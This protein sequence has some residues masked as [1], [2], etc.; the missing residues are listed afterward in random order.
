MRFFL[1]TLLPLAIAS[2]ELAF[3]FPNAVE[4]WYAQSLY[5]RVVSFFALV[6]HQS[7]SWAE[8]ALALMI[9]GAVSM[10]LRFARSKKRHRWKRGLVVLW[11][12]AGALAWAF[13]LLWGFNYARPPL[14]TRMGLATVDVDPSRVLKL[15]ERTARRTADLYESLALVDGPSELTISM[16]ELDATIDR[17]YR[18]L[19]LPGDVIVTRGAPV[20]TLAS[21]TMLSYLGISGIFIPFTGEPSVNA[22]QP[23]VALPLVVAHEKAHQ[24]GITHEGEANFVAFL[25]CASKS[26]PDYLRYAAHLFATR[27]LLEEAG[28]YW[29]S[30]EVRE[31]W[32]FLG[33]GPMQDVRAIHEFWQRYEGPASAIASRVNDGYLHAVR[34]PKG[35]ES[36]TLVVRLLMALEQ[37]GKF[38][39][40]DQI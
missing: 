29:P 14:E 6:N 24:R 8:V 40:D 11:S 4:S 39:L 26:A 5:P 37:E 15:G 3:R 38:L 25:V 21:S 18:E 33:D 23:D 17:L 7:F 34:V 30:E 20:K 32:A 16:V 9:I 27:H 2:G 19:A 22:L 1:A 28:M 35:V 12:L 31:A 36:Y 13:L 10:L